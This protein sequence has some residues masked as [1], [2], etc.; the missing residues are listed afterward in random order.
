VYGLTTFDFLVSS[1]GLHILSLMYV[2]VFWAMIPCG[3]EST[4][5]PGFRIDSCS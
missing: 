4:V 3:D 1:F 2:V 5:H